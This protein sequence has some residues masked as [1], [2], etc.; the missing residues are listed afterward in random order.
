MIDPHAGIIDRRV[1]DAIRIGLRGPDVVVDR[2]GKR[3]AGGVELEDRDDLA[4]LRLLDQI[5]VV[6]APIRR[7]IGAETAAGM[8][9]VAARPRPHVENAHLQHVA[10]LRILDRDRAG[11]QM[12]ADAFAG[13]ADERPLGRAG[14]AARDRLVLARPVEH[15]LRAGIA[16]D[17]SL[18]IVVGVV[19]Q[20]LDGGAVARAQRQRWRDLLAE[21]APV[22]GGRRNRQGKMPHASA[23]SSGR[24]VNCGVRRV[25][26]RPPEPCRLPSR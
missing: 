18:I 26:S 12:D 23:S 24:D 16:C 6:K 19:R 15:A 20:R 17:H 13:A 8:T 5:V 4:R 9:G 10:R 7:G 1:Y 11:Q 14:A 22:N 3:L 21:I 25:I 2:L